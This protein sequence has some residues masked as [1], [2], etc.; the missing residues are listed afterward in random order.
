MELSLDDLKKL[1]KNK[2]S[3][4]EMQ[5]AL[6]KQNQNQKFE[7]K[8]DERFW[9]CE[10]DDAG[11]GS[12]VIRFLPKRPDDQLPWVK[13]ISHGFKGPSG[14]WYVENSLTMLG[15]KDPIAELNSKL[16]NTGIKANQDIASKQK[17]KIH[18]IANILVIKDPKHPENEGKVKLFKFG[19]KIYDMLNDK[20]NPTFEDEDPVDVFDIWEGANFKLRIR[21][22]EGYANYDKSEFSPVSELCDGDDEEILKVMNS[23]H[24]LGEFIAPDKFKTYEQ[25]KARLDE[26][27]GDSESSTSAEED[28]YE[29]VK[30]A[31]P[32][33]K[34]KETP[35]PKKAPSKPSKVE[36]DDEEED[37]VSSK[38]SKFKKLVDD[39]DDDESFFTKRSSKSVDDD[40]P[41]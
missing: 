39:D 17:R 26:V 24:W 23:L 11:N 28:V 13:I 38:M 1:K 9:H 32:K 14:K 2:N 29:N 22:V 20:V 15:Q 7:K 31:E 10:R 8:V 37:D 18:Y 34:I 40:A 33:T 41:F 21:D 35:A 6:A 25:L 30:A 16:W 5:E 3:L 27:L 19:K 36:E 4:K 12:A